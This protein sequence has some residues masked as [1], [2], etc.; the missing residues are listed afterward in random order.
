VCQNGIFYERANENALKGIPV[1]LE[2]IR[3]FWSFFMFQEYFGHF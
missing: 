2:G 1:I 3:V